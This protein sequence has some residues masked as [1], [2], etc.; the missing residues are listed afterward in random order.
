MLFYE[1]TGKQETEYDDYDKKKRPRGPQP[2]TFNMISVND[3]EKIWLETEGADILKYLGI[4]ATNGRKF[5]SWNELILAI[6][7]VQKRNEIIN[8]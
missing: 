7:E 1:E 3:I 2:Y 6:K 8:F 4:L 5:R